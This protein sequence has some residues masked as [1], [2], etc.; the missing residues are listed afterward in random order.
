MFKVKIY[1]NCQIIYYII[2][3]KTPFSFSLPFPDLKLFYCV[4][5]NVERKDSKLYIASIIY[6]LF[7]Y[8]GCYNM[9]YIHVDSCHWEHLRTGSHMHKISNTCIC[10]WMEIAVSTFKYTWTPLNVLK[11]AYIFANIY[12]CI[13]IYAFR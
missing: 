13:R 6:F 10:N 9:F 5:K 7:S 4:I 8:F 2:F 3:C 11:Y 12:I 1:V